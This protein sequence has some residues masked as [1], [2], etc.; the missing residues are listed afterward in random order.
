MLLLCGT[1]YGNNLVVI[2]YKMMMKFSRDILAKPTRYHAQ[3]V[4]FCDTRGPS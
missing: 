1:N 2:S 3:A 4:L